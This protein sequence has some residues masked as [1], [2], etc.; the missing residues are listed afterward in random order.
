MNFPAENNTMLAPML[1]YA[2][3]TVDGQDHVPFPQLTA[4]STRY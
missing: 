1:Q 3:A 2:G 4:S